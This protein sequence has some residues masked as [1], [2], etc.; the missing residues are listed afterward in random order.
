[1]GGNSFARVL[2]IDF[3]RTYVGFSQIEEKQIAYA[4]HSEDLN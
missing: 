3:H 2:T 1:M 4:F